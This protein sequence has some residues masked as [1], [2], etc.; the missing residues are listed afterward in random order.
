[1][2]GAPGWRRYIRKWRAVGRDDDGT[3]GRDHMGMGREEERA[4]TMMVAMGM[5]N[6]MRMGREE[7]RA[8]TPVPV[9]P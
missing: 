9:R 2:I 5:G 6:A 1:M 4:R 8:R 3:M 7:D